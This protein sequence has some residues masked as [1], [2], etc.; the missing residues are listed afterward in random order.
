MRKKHI[1]IL[2]SIIVFFTVSLGLA[3]L[4]IYLWQ[5][6]QYIQP[7]YSSK[8]PKN[9]VTAKPISVSGQ[10]APAPE[11]TEVLRPRGYPVYPYSVIEGGAHTVDE[12]RSSIAHDAIVAV[13]YQDFDVERD[14]I[15][16]LVSARQAYVS[17]RI[18]NQVYWTKKKLNLPKGEMVITDGKNVSRTRCGNR[19]SEKPLLPVTE[20]EPP[21]EVFDQPEIFEELPSQPPVPKPIV[22]VSPKYTY[23]GKHSYNQSTPDAIPEPSSILLLSSGIGLAWIWMRRR[24]P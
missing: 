10:P 13:H 21:L 19:L 5:Q 7:D 16:Q 24:K 8:P 6:Q 17:F 12:F 2:T 11:Q 18:K 23:T 14:G 22:P 1:A 9:V 20:L 4:G 3:G 15:I